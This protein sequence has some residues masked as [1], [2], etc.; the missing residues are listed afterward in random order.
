[1]F[2]AYA[3]MLELGYI[4]AARLRSKRGTDRTLTH[5]YTSQL[6]LSRTCA[7]HRQ[8]MLQSTSLLRLKW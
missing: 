5:A 7:S 3:L 8:C 2:H 1:M 4:S 6:S